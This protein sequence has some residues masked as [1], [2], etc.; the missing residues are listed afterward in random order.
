MQVTQ[1]RIAHVDFSSTKFILCY[2]V[3]HIP[4]SISKCAL[5]LSD[6]YWGIEDC[7]ENVIKRINDNGG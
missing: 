1:R 3:N 6:A 2:L 4:G 5:Q 7:V